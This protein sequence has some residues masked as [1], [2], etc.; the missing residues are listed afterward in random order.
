MSKAT[1]SNTATNEIH[2]SASHRN[3]RKQSAIAMVANIPIAYVLRISETVPVFTRHYVQPPSQVS[4]SR[5]S[6]SFFS[7]TPNYESNK[8]W[9]SNVS[10]TT[11]R[12][13]L[14]NTCN[15]Y[16]PV[17]RISS[18]TWTRLTKMTKTRNSRWNCE[19]I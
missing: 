12:P 1:S 4:H 18:R 17:H 8:R 15:N 10:P 5:S 11:L 19:S 7:E 6:P 2:T 9:K 3:S 14:A 16:I 13:K